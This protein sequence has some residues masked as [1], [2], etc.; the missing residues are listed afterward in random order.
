MFNTPP[1]KI[2]GKL[3]ATILGIFLLIGSVGAGV[4]LIGQN[5]DIREKAGTTYCYAMQGTRSYLNCD[6]TGRTS[7]NCCTATS[8][9][10]EI[11]SGGNGS[12]YEYYIGRYDAREGGT[13]KEYVEYKCL[14]NNTPTPTSTPTGTPTPTP[15]SSPTSSPTV[16]PTPTPEPNPVCSSV[17]AYDTNWNLLTGV[18]LS[19]LSA[20]SVVRFTIS[21]TPADQID[22]ARFT[23]NGVLKPETTNKKPGTNEY[24]FEYTIPTGVTSFTVTA[25]IHH[26]TL[27]WF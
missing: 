10:S 26:L 15:T 7:G 22:K 27:G 2:S 23:I 19:N 18:Q 9:W 24:Y 11:L 25:Q 12:P 16:T 3:I 20:G 8:P 1:K 21:G 6:T 4:V 13:C 5:Q 17:K 14:P